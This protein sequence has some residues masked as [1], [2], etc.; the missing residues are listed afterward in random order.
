MVAI[1]R[2][3]T[4]AWAILMLVTI[5]ITADSSSLFGRCHDRVGAIVFECEGC[6]Q[7]DRTHR[8]FSLMQAT[9]RSAQPWH[10]SSQFLP[11]CNSVQWSAAQTVTLALLAT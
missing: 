11:A 2:A 1:M 7:L 4:A 6:P 9:K 8:N 5:V 3:L 10:N